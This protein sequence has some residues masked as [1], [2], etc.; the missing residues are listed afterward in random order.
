[1]NGKIFSSWNRGIDLHEKSEYLH[2]L[3]TKTIATVIIKT[4]GFLRD[5]WG[6]NPFTQ[7]DSLEVP[8]CLYPHQAGLQSDRPA[9]CGG[10]SGVFQRSR[11]M[12]GWCTQNVCKCCSNTQL[13]F[14][15]P[16]DAL[17]QI[18]KMLR[19]GWARSWNTFGLPRRSFELFFFF[20]VVSFSSYSRRNTNQS[21]A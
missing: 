16:E 18:L 13:C 14:N 19:V 17:G 4:F 3:C 9:W 2:N 20:Q 5:F 11:Y 8:I 1:M 12:W 7:W 21:I 6:L 10:I 15:K